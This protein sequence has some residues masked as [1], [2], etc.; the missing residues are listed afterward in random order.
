M[1]SE[2]QHIWAEIQCPLND[3]PVGILV[4][5]DVPQRK[6]RNHFYGVGVKVIVQLARGDQD[7][8]QQLLDLWIPGFGLVEDVANEVYWSLDL[9]HVTDLLALDD[10]GCTNHPISCHDV[11]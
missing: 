1:A 7:S 4:A 3:A 9:V 10:N 11:K 2:F 8:I 5:Q 6:L